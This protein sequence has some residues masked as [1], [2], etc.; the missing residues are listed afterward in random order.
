MYGMSRVPRP[1]RTTSNPVANGSSVPVWPTRRARTA[2]RTTDTTSCDVTPA[3]LSTSN[4]PPGSVVGVSIGGWLGVL[5]LRK[6]VLDSRRVRD[7]F[8]GSEGDLR[9][10]PQAERSSNPRSQMSSDAR[11]AFEGRVAVGLRSH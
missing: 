1:T 6:Q 3:G 4:T 5:D 7:A 11:Q 10:Q 9:R 8:V 2:R